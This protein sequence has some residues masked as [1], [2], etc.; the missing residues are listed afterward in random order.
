MQNLA[1][2]E[3]HDELR[4]DV[5]SGAVLLSDR[6]VADEYKS[7]KAMMNNVRDVSTEINT[8]KQKLSDLESVKDDMREIKELLRGLAK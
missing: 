5:K 7:R 2:I 3:E 6:N 8:I 4:K 1:R